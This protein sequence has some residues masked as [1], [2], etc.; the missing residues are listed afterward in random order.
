MVCKFFDKKSSGSGVK[1]EN[2]S[3]K[4]L[5]EELHQPII[6]KSNKRKVHSPLYRQYLG[7]RSSRYA[8]ASLIKDLNFYYVLLILIGNIHGLFLYTINKELQLLILFKK[9]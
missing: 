9:L 8:I 3:N 7:C 2:F 5:A 6:R 1:N 4:Q